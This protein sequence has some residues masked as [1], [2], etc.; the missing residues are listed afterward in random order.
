MAVEKKG[1]QRNRRST[2][3]PRVVLVPVVAATYPL[4]WC[5]FSFIELKPRRRS[6]RSFWCQLNLQD[7]FPLIP[8][9]HIR[10]VLLDCNSL[11]VP[12]FYQ[13]RAESL[14]DPPPFKPKAEAS[15]LKKN[16][17]VEFSDEAFEAEK[18]W[19]DRRLRTFSLRFRANESC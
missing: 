15:P 10:R 12:A 3:W 16:K 19:L 8:V 9:A 2:I 11:Y 4:L 1:K 18:T 6:S 14:A 17:G 13:L 7:H 5:V